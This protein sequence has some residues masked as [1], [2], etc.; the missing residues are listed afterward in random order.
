MLTLP[1]AAR[2]GARASGPVRAAAAALALATGAGI[3]VVGPFTRHWSQADC[4][5]GDVSVEPDIVIREGPDAGFTVR[6]PIENV[7]PDG[8][9]SI[10]VRLS[11]S[12]GTFE[13]GQELAVPAGASRRLAYAFPEPTVD[14]SNVQAIVNCTP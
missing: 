10:R 13:R 11:T 5:L 3:Y 9:V 1:S 6:F 2:N 7:G 4:R 12:E 14:A 8:T